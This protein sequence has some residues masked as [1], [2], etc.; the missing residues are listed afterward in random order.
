MWV[1]ALVLLFA[2]VMN[3]LDVGT[4]GRRINENPTS[5]SSSDT[6]T[7]SQTPT[8]NST[9]GIANVASITDEDLND[10]VKRE[11]FTQDMISTLQ[12]NLSKVDPKF[13]EIDIRES[14]S[15]YTEDKRVIYL[16]LRDPKTG[17]YYPMN[18]L[19]YVAL[20][21]IAHF[22]NH[23]N[24]GHTPEFN[25]LFNSLLCRAS[26][27]GVYDPS[28]PHSDW[29]CGVDI[30]GISAPVC[31]NIEPFSVDNLDLKSDPIEIDSLPVMD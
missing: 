29:Y 15:S 17:G 2:V 27:T 12:S 26:Q 10:P 1:I 13:G 8:T 11:R 7:S 31:D 5:A 30:R 3:P 9:I 14:S 19:V 21:E 16:C 22:F 24:F 4:S 25:K 6:T 18:T 20:H 28:Q 23:A